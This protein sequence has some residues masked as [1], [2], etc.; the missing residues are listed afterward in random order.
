M[1]F[2]LCKIEEQSGD[3]SKRRP[4]GR[5]VDVLLPL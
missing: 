5:G 4:A 1:K 3:F 2:A